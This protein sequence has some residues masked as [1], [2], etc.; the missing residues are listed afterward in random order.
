MSTTAI[1]W[2]DVTW[3]PV[4]GCSKI[5]PGCKNCYAE[6]FAERWRGIPGHAYEQGFDMRLAPHKLAEPLRWTA[7]RTIFVNSMSDLF[8]PRVP[9]EYVADVLSVIELAPWHTFQLLTK[10][11]QRQRAFDLESYGRLGSIEN[12]WVGVSVEDKQYGVRRIRILQETRAVHRF[13]SIEP[14]LEDLG[15]LDLS[16]IEWVIVG[17]ESG[18]GARPMRPEWVRAIRDQCV[19]Q[20]VLFFF[21]QWGAWVTTEQMPEHQWDASA[22]VEQQGELYRIG[23]K[24]TGRLLDGRTYDAM[25]SR[26]TTPVAPHTARNHHIAQVKAWAKEWAQHELT[27][28]LHARRQRP[29]GY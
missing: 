21:K 9:F 16:G 24:G 3:N 18:R 4:R 25:P 14:L 7:P 5:S 19:E 10:R 13:L 27:W 26:S 23:K 22:G 1:E 17:G 20:G 28:G 6:T 2:T 29:G 11:A 12:L 8:E 15:E